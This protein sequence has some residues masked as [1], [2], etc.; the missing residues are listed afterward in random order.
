MTPI[1]I[2]ESFIIKANE[3]AQTDN[4]AVDRA[5][6]CY[7]YNEASIRFVE[8]F[9][10]KKNDDDIR[11]LAPVLV[12]ST[13]TK[14]TGNSKEQLAE[15]PN[16]YLDLSNVNAIASSECCTKVAMDTWEIKSDNENIIIND[17]DNEPSIEYREVPFYIQDG[18]I[19]FLVNNFE[20]DEV[21]LTYYKY[22]TKIELNDPD[23][24]ESTFKNPDTQLEFDDKALNRI[25]SIAVTDYD[26]NTNNPKFQGDKSRVVS[27]F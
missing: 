13:I 16:N 14:I 21:E 22:P 5:R 9:A 26:L 11:Y 2:Y 15:L 18:K 7:L 17:A 25:V 4:I 3:N 20:I 10:D 8:W 27:K 19:K 1:E 12:S 24:P 6:F 23:D